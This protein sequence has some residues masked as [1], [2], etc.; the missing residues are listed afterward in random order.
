M[1]L[2]LRSGDVPCDWRPSKST[3]PMS[4]IYYMDISIMETTCIPS[5]YGSRNSLGAV[6]FPSLT[7]LS[8]V[9]TE[10][11]SMAFRL[12]LARALLNP[13]VNT[14]RRPKVCRISPRVISPSTPATHLSKFRQLALP[15]SQY[16]GTKMVPS[17]KGS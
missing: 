12:P 11:V 2:L 6:C 5:T 17:T 9:W 10:F 1:L 15:A 7:R 3:G 4:H 16:S 8:A 13:V 14:A